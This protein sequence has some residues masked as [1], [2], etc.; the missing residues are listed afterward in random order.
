MDPV[1]RKK[2]KNDLSSTYNKKEEQD[3][4]DFELILEA[5]NFKGYD[6]FIVFSYCLFFD[7]FEICFLLINLTLFKK[8]G[9]DPNVLGAKRRNTFT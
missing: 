3:L 8:Y 5:Y 7:C 9:F 6:K 2:R 4:K 1:S